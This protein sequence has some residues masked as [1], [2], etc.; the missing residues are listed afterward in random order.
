MSSGG[1]AAPIETG[2]SGLARWLVPAAI[3]AAL[4]IFLLRGSLPA[5]TTYPDSL[6]IPF[7]TW[8][9][10]AMTWVKVN[11]TWLTRSIAAVIDVPLRFSF[12]LLSKGFKFGSG[13]AAWFLPRLAWSAS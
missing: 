6:V 1:I 11:F 5:L 2:R 4:A 13:D 12:N 9:A 7:K 3:V 10:D 8:V